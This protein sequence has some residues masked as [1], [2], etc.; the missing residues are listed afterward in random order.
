MRPAL[1]WAAPAKINLWLRVLGRRPDGYHELDTGFAFLDW[2]D[3]LAFAEADALRVDCDAPGLAGEA[4]LVHRVLAAFAREAGVAPRLHVRIEKR[5]PMQAGLGG[6]SSDAATAL[7]AANLLWDARWPR[8]RLMDFAKD[9]GADIPVFLFG[10]AA[11]ARGIGERLAPL[12]IPRAWVAV[13][14]PDEAPLS[15]REVFARLDAQPPGARLQPPGGADRLALLG[16]NDLEETAGAM[17]PRLARLLARAREEGL[18]AWMTGSGN[19]IVA[20]ADTRAGAEAAARVLGGQAA[21][22]RVARVDARH[23]LSE[24]AIGA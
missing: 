3:A 23:P 2:A 19:A 5:I 10:R 16:T 11:H 4:N 14:V 1:V 8:A 22:V 6:G 17:R 18:R 13:A 24:R 20:W 15:T 9:F 7:L 21:L 12:G